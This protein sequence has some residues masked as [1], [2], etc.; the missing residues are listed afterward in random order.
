ML[1]HIDAALTLQFRIPPLRYGL[2]HFRYAASL[3]AARRSSH[4]CLSALIASA[5][6]L[7]IGLITQYSLGLYV[8]I[9]KVN[10]VYR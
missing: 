8:G 1:S 4:E 9:M 2:L 5:P 7:W 10:L 6:S 3:R